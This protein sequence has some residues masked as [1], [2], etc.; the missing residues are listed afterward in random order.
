MIPKLEFGQL[1]KFVVS[2][3]F[4]LMAA[5]V[6]GPWAILRDQGALLVS[7]ETLED[8]TPRAQRVL[9]LK[10]E[11]VEW[12]ATWYPWASLVLFLAGASL[13]LWGLVRWWVRQQVAD[14]R[15][16]VDLEVQRRTLVPLTAEEEELRLDTE[17]EEALAG[18]S[19]ADTEA[20]RPS[21][22]QRPASTAHSGTAPHPQDPDVPTPAPAP[23][24]TRLETDVVALRNRVRETEALALR[25]LTEALKDTHRVESGVKIRSNDDIMGYAD[26]VAIALPN[27][28]SW[29]FVID[30]KFGRYPQ[31]AGNRL[32]ESL[33]S[34]A[35]AARGLGPS[36]SLALTIFV[37]ENDEQVGRTQR[38]LTRALKRAREALAV[39]VS[40]LVITETELKLMPAAALRRLLT[41]AAIE[42]LGDLPASV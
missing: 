41:Q 4:V 36:R 32:S 27:S 15:E 40:A 10:Q 42:S 5:A 3:G 26:L 30:V 12:I 7:S 31:N 21:G 11:H 17:V 6:V 22:E 16:D 33:L 23:G 14:E 8:L 2:L 24:R 29:N 28:S 20:E 25:R 38:N 34:G 35:A 18:A 37:V 39:P 1:Y 13:A 19:V 9:E